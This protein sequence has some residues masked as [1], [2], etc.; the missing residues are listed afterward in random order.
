LAIHAIPFQAHEG[1]PSGRANH[2]QGP[3]R[4]SAVGDEIPK[5]IVGLGREGETTRKIR[6]SSESPSVF[7]CVAVVLPELPVKSEFEWEKYI[8]DYKSMGLF[9]GEIGP[10]TP[11]TQIPSLKK[12]HRA[13]EM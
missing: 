7:C 12:L 1:H 4:G 8:K 3:A 11:S 13:D 2:Q 5:A 6:K 10:S 9:F